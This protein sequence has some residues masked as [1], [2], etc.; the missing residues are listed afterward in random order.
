M[1]HWRHPAV[2]PPYT[3]ED[4]KHSPFLVFYEV[5]RACDLLCKHCR[6]Y[7]QPKRHPLELT[8]VQSKALLDQLAAFP[9]RPLLVITG[10]DPMKRADIYELIEYAVASGLQVALTPSATPLV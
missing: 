1:T 5:T 6:A 7:A 10:G 3:Q 9:K 8:T 2:K 4:F